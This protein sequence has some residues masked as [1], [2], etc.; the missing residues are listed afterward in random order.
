MAPGCVYV[1]ARPISLLAA[2]CEITL[3]LCV[4][5][6]AVLAPSL[7]ICG[8]LP[9]KQYIYVHGWTC[10]S[11]ILVYLLK[12][13]NRVENDQHV[14]RTGGWA[15]RSAVPLTSL[16][17]RRRP[18]WG[19]LARCRTGYY[20]DTLHQ[21]KKLIANLGSKCCLLEDLS[22]LRDATVYF[23]MPLSFSSHAWQLGPD[24][25]CL[26]SFN[27]FPLMRLIEW[28][29]IHRGLLMC[30]SS[31]VN[32]PSYFGKLTELHSPL[33]P[34][35]VSL[36]KSRA[37]C[38]SSLIPDVGRVSGSPRRPCFKVPS[39]P[40]P[41]PSMLTGRAV[42]TPPSTCHCFGLMAL[43]P[44]DRVPSGPPS[45]IVSVLTESS[46]SWTEVSCLHLQL[47]KPSWP[48]VCATPSLNQTIQP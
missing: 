20:Y 36:S 23:G 27:R 46:V 28:P 17:P 7:I 33:A 47:A 1:C 13:N 42:A 6:V 2:Q 37:C 21:L 5:I 29:F 22:D 26:A 3:C 32:H 4:I 35:N 8:H 30:H 9:L 43:W 39:P 48:P 19:D 14:C 15:T 34:V 40:L 25:L 44:A 10:T 45:I 41:R 31:N 16:S 24:N 11:K 38:V 12:R 18:H